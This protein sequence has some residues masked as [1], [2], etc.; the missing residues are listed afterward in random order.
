[1]WFSTLNELRESRHTYQNNKDWINVFEE[2]EL[3]RRLFR[4]YLQSA[5]RIN[6]LEYQQRRKYEIEGKLNE[7]IRNIKFRDSSLTHEAA[8][9]AAISYME[10]ESREYGGLEQIIPDSVSKLGAFKAEAAE[11]LRQLRALK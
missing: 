2:Q 11:L 6:Q 8:V 4:Y 7:T 10:S 1:M 5:D 9:K 3:R